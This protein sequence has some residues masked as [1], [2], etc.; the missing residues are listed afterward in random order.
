MRSAKCSELL[1]ESEAHR[2]KSL[3]VQSA[4]SRP[5]VVPNTQVDANL[6]QGLNIHKYIFIYLDVCT[7]HNNGTDIA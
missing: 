4:E 1:I 7:D 6:D 5:D 2:A 3:E